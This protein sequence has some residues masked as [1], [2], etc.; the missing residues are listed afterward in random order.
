MTEQL[1]LHFTSSLLQYMGP[2]WSVWR[3]GGLGLIHPSLQGDG[4]FFHRTKGGNCLDVT[5]NP[6]P[7]NPV[8]C[9]IG[10]EKNSPSLK[11]IQKSQVFRCECRL[12]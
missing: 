12:S 4:I 8:P 5:M 3:G 9:G 11:V 6:N 2:P 7:G 1:S 10:Q